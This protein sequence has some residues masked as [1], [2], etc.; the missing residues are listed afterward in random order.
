ML[1]RSV[2]DIEYENLVMDQEGETRKLLAYCGLP[3]DDACLAF[4]KTKRGV[5]T[6]SAVQV[7]QP[8]YKDSVELWKQHAKQLEALRKVING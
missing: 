6:A 5:A 8:M 3:W 7:R 1:F 4:H 2:Y